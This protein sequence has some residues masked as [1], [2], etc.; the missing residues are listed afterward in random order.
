[1]K[2]T[3]AER[4]RLRSVLLTNGFYYVMETPSGSPA[5]EVG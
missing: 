1:M 5:G 2:R 4:R 3:T